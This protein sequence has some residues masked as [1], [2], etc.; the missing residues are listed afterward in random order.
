MKSPPA[1]GEREALAS[2]NGYVVEASD[3]LVGEVETP[4]FPPDRSQPD[5]LVL[6]IGGPVRVRR[7]V[8]AVA[9]VEEVDS[10]E[11]LVRVR[12][13]KGQIESLPEHLPLAI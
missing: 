9:L 1:A 10:G 11:R 6:R 12:G 8:I 7:P 5:Y 4:L 2:C 3:G 13:T